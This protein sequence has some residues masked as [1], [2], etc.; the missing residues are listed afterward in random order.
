MKG[1]RHSHSLAPCSPMRAPRLFFS[2]F[3]QQP[4]SPETFRAVANPSWIGSGSRTAWLLHLSALLRLPLLSLERDAHRRVKCASLDC[5][6]SRLIR[7]PS[8][9]HLQCS[10][11]SRGPPNTILAGLRCDCWLF[12]G[13]DELRALIVDERA[14]QTT[15]CTMDPVGRRDRETWSKPCDPNALLYS[16]FLYTTTLARVFYQKL[17][18]HKCVWLFCFCPRWLK[19]ATLVHRA[20]LLY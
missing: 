8:L 5:P 2:A 16:T 11:S 7:S 6:S 19:L 14:L 18:R 9:S 3:R 1:K 10:P 12:C 13:L 15:N 20:L 4:R 17:N